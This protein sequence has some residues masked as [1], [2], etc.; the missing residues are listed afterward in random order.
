[1]VLTFENI[2]ERKNRERD[3]A[4]IAAVTD[5][6]AGLDNVPETMKRVEE[7]IARHFDL[8]W[9]VIAE[10]GQA[11]ETS[12]IRHG[13]HAPD[14]G[15]LEGTYRIRDFLAGQLLATH[16]RGEPTVVSDTQEDQGVNAASY[17]A[18]GIRSFVAVPLV[19]NRICRFRLSICDRKIRVWLG[20]EVELMRELAQR[21]WARLERAHGDEALR[22]SEA[23]LR[24]V[25]AELREADR[26]KN[27]FLAMVGHELRNPLAAIRSGLL[28]MRSEKARPESREAA[29][30]IITEQLAHVERLVDD[31]LDLTRI[32]HGSLQLR[33][34]KMAV[35]DAL[36]Q[37]IE[38][39]RSQ[40][41]PEGFVIDLRAPSSPLE[42]LGDPV[43]LTQVFTNVLGNAVKYSGDSRLIEVSAARD[44]DAAVVRVRDHGVGIPPEVL[45]L[46]FEPFVQA[47]PGATLQAGLGLGLAVVRELIHLHDGE[48]EARSAGEKM[49][50]ELVLRL[51][52][53]LL[54]QNEPRPSEA[55]A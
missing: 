32:V 39:V 22:R 47:K 36:R 13:W 52:L 9:C 16:L 27:D 25:A 34:E 46:I 31:L 11:P 33:R 44:G 54:N 51:P 12:V 2:T 7:R 8:P 19:Q 6:L 53:C 5:D 28:L 30:P 20:D 24:T 1:M 48:V 18:L 14:V 29:M 49:G 15:P 17:R 37:A 50:S 3:Q 43:R 42:V 21:I 26:R 40:A 35:Q 41:E 45:P 23:Q 55:L 10:P 38:M 4:L